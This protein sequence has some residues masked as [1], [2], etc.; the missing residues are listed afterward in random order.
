M[1]PRTSKSIKPGQP[2]S[3]QGTV[4]PDHAL[5]TAYLAKTMDLLRQSLADELDKLIQSKKDLLEAREDLQDNLPGSPN[6]TDKRADTSQSLNALRAQAAAYQTIQYKIAQYKRMESSPYF[7][8]VDFTE[9]GYPKESIYIGRGTLIDHANGHIRIYDWRAPVSSIFYRYGLGA[10]SYLAPAGEISGQVTLKRQYDIQEGQLAYFIDTDINI[11]DQVLRYALSQNATPQMKAIVE[12]IQKEQDQI[13]RDMDSELLLVQGSAGS[14]KTSVALHRVAYLMYQGLTSPLAAHHIIIVSPNA[15]F[16]QYIAQVLPDLGEENIASLTFDTVFSNLDIGRPVET[17]SQQAEALLGNPDTE[18]AA[19]EREMLAFKTSSVFCTLLDRLIWHY[20]HKILAF[21]DFYYNGRYLARRQDL[22]AELLRDRVKIPLTKRLA[23][24]QERL[25]EKIHEAK[26]DRIPSLEEFVSN[27]PDHQLEIRGFARLLSVKRSAS[28]VQAAQQITILDPLSIYKLLFE[29]P[30]LFGRLAKDLSLPENIADIQSACRRRLD[31]ETLSHVDGAALTYLKTKLDGP[32]AYPDIQQVIVDEVQDYG[33]L[34]FTLLNLW[35]PNAR[36]TV[37]GDI[38]QSM[39]RQASMDLYDE[40]Q[41][42]L[43]KKKAAMV[44]LRQSYRSS[45]EI[46]RFCRRFLD[47]PETVEPFERH[48][49]EPEVHGFADREAADQALIEGIRECRQAQC[50][51]IAVICKTMSDA[52]DLYQRLRGQFA[53]RL[54]TEDTPQI[55]SGTLILPVY[56]AKGL[57]FDAVLAYGTD[58]GHY[59]T[60]DDRRLLYIACTRA[61]HHLSLYYFGSKSPLI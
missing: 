52:K 19:L 5:E 15:L 25:L 31:T 45:Y 40:I 18:A 12:T 60:P 27:H 46:G 58:A 21:P 48:E 14:G 37:L 16:S 1:Q 57:E 44:I 30:V 6:D 36:Y 53:L 11:D 9:T 17:R 34:H 13:I 42:V 2:A 43:H 3:A 32:V 61:L 41:R 10:A 56:L 29:D 20:E 50:R 22:K 8:R 24:I 51:S 47:N 23:Q 28:L 26:K 4:H 49:S 54:V 39:E 38:S 35:F 55:G 59:S 33:A 7:G